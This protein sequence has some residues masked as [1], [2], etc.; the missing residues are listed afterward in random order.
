MGKIRVKVIGDEEQEQKQK[1]DARKKKEAKKAAED[2]A[3]KG[4]EPVI[5]AVENTATPSQDTKAVKEKIKES[6][7]TVKKTATTAR[8]RSKR[9]QT[10]RVLVDKNKKYSLSQALELLPK[11]KL[12]TFD[13]TV[14]L[15]INTTETG[16]SGTVSLPHG[17]GKPTKVAIASDSV[18]AKIEK[19]VI[20]FDVL[21]APPSMMPKLAKVARVLG[22]K[23][24]MPNPK[25]GTISDKPEDVAKK[26]EGG[27][28]RFKTESKA[29]VI[30]MS[31][32]KLSFGDRK[33]SENILTAVKAV[34]TS[35]I[36]KAVLKSTMS[37]GIK[38]DF[39]TI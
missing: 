29:P 26:F 11:L 4:Q 27:Q 12:S 17:S 6:K 16:F 24:L 31:V 7:K 22:P 20:D 10:T 19:G 33:L 8:Q 28:M 37:P 18:I 34:Q 2:K 21:I 3:V 38:L 14:E 35:R 30:H 36:K 39:S 32:G 23:G 9:Y 1:K 15:H 5:E 25:N 13:E